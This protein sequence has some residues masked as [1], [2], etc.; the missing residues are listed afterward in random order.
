[1]PTGMVETNVVEIGNCESNSKSF[2]ER[3]LTKKSQQR[4][5]KAVGQSA[6][7]T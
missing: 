2:Q 1:M 4:E 3:K 5:V 7:G 6:A